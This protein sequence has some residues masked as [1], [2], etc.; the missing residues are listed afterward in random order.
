[1]EAW[2][3]VVAA[4][5]GALA[6]VMNSVAG[7]GTLITYPAL[8]WLGLDPIVANATS[9][10]ALWPGY[11]AAALGF[12]K[13]VARTRG[14]V[15]L[16]AIPS[17]VGGLIGAFILLRTPSRTFSFI[18]PFLVLGA[19]IMLAFQI[20][21]PP[22]RRSRGRWAPFGAVSFQLAAAVYGGYFGAG[23]GFMLL[24]GFGLMGLRDVLE[25]SALK[26]ALTVLI[27]GVALGYFIASGAIRWTDGLVM[28]AGA[29]AGGFGGTVIARRVG[30]RTVRI[31]VVVIGLA[32][33]VGLMVR[34]FA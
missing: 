29:A 15:V 2:K 19:T 4:V 34:A 23:L 10:L 6:G 3:L 24:V 31:A 33:S 26:N 32:V 21:R 25:M 12:R 30:D 17:L 28:A 5:A 16:L 18:V 8:V 22:P 7:G 1:V 14:W 20:R 9:T 27:N 11:V 13:E